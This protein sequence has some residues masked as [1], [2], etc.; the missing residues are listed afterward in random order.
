MRIRF[1]PTN[2]GA[3]VRSKTSVSSLAVDVTWRSGISRAFRIRSGIMMIV[4]GGVMQLCYFCHQI[5]ERTSDGDRVACSMCGRPY[6]VTPIPGIR[7]T[8][9][10]SA[11]R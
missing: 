3:T 7:S 6:L 1:E 2:Y 10:L 11:L 4:M 8:S 9:A 5:T